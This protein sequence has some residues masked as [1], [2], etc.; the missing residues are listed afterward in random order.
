MKRIHVLAALGL[1]VLVLGGCGG[2]SGGPGPGSQS[3]GNGDPAGTRAAAALRPLFGVA[4]GILPYPTDLYFAGSTDGTLRLPNTPF[5]PNSPAINA[6]DGFSTTAPITVRFSSPIDATTLSPASI[7]VLRLTLDNATK[8]PIVPPTAGAQLPR[9]LVYGTDFTAAVSTDFDAAGS[10]LVITPTH[11]LDASSGATNIGYL[12]LLTSGIKDTAGDASAPDADYATVKAGALADLAA[13]LTVPKCGTVTDATLNEVCQLTFAHLALASAIGLDPTTVA[14][15]FSFSTQSIADTLTVLAETY[16]ATPVPAGTIVAQPTGATTKVFSSALPGIA[17]VWAGRV[18]LPYYLTAPS[19]ADPTAPLTKYWT[20]AGASPAPGIDPTSRKLTRF[21]P[22]P[23]VTSQQTV[24]LLLG[25][26]NAGSG[27][28]E[29]ANGWPVVVFMHGVTRTRADA[30]AVMDS[31]A[32]RCFVVAAIDQP[33]HGIVATDPAAALR[34]AGFERNFDLPGPNGSVASSGFYFINLTSLLTSRDNV[35]QAES[36]LLWLAHVLPSLKLSLNATPDIDATQI[37]LAG[38]SLG[39]IVSFA[40]LAM[41]NT[42]YL[43]GMLSVPGGGIADLLRDSPT[44]SVPINQG[45]A[46][47]GLTPGL[48]LYSNFFRDAQTAVDSGDPVNFVA[49]AI[50]QRPILMQQVVG[51][52][53]LPDGTASLPD[54]VIPNSATQRLFAAAGASAVQFHTAGTTPLAPGKGAYV[55]FIYGNHGSLLDPS[56]TAN[57]ALTNGGTTQ[58]MQTEAVAFAL[59]RGQAVTIVNPQLIH[60]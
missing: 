31:Y 9:P 4:T 14:L 30:I 54:Q 60:P 34:Q 6:L 59:A 38:Q 7:V 40:P 43:S 45:L 18:T 36:D 13:H 58:E 52:G 3:A 22:V 39:S 47:Q 48:T 41:P 21:N 56:G 25:V 29:P 26:P 20:A 8:A 16:A 53:P 19:A 17:D 42:P 37:Q 35:R 23:A 33:L 51:G 1:S 46:A 50:A 24:P 2:G 57:T 12:V 55:N 32:S 10:T 15:S 27:C 44:F 11:P 28:A 5:L 49:A